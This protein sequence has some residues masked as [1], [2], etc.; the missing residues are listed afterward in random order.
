MKN[1]KTFPC[2]VQRALLIVTT[3]HVIQ[4]ASPG[5]R[6]CLTTF[7]RTGALCAR[8]PRAVRQWL[9]GDSRTPLIV[10]REGE[11][12]FIRRYRPHPPETIALHL[13]VI[14]H[15]GSAETIRKHASLT[16]RENEVLR[17]LAMDQSYRQIAEYLDIS[18]RTVGKNLERIYAKLGVAGWISAANCCDSHPPPGS[19][20]AGAGSE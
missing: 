6:A 11:R 14:D 1:P 2:C 17:C 10:K 19:R 7:F 18:C 20:T 4:Y 15:R 5:A 13:E 9:T 16:R 8:L 12:I 3:H